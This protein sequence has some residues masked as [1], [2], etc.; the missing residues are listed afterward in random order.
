MPSLRFNLKI[1]LCPCCCIL[2]D[3]LD[4]LDL[5]WGSLPHRDMRIQKLFSTLGTNLDGYF[6]THICEHK[7][8]TR[9]NKACPHIAKESFFCHISNV[10]S[11]YQRVFP[12]LKIGIIHVCVQE[13]R[14]HLLYGHNIIGVNSNDYSWF[15]I[16]YFLYGKRLGK[17]ERHHC[18]VLWQKI[19]FGRQDCNIVIKSQFIGRFQRPEN[20]FLTLCFHSL[21]IHRFIF[22]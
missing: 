9:V 18:F 2:H 22:Y 19:L 17:I 12:P 6:I 1:S 16:F 21:N 15:R 5:L 8:I 3:R 14:V 11:C 4:P 20:E 13:I 7:I 10:Q